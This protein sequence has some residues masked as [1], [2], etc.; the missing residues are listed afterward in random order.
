[1]KAIFVMYDSLRRDMLPCYGGNVAEMPNFKRLAERSVTFDTSYVGSL[2]CMPVRRE[3]QTGRLNFLHR[4][5]GPMEP[6]DVSMPEILKQNGIHSHLATDHYHYVQDG[7]ATYQG[8]FSSWACYR[9]QESDAWKGSVNEAPDL[10]RVMGFEKMPE[11]LKAMRTRGATQNAVNRGF[12]HGEK[13]YPQT[14]TFDDGVDFIER[15]ADADN[16]FVQIE[17]FDPHEPF[18][19][20]ES[21]TGRYFDANDPFQKD[22]PPYAEVSEDPDE[23]EKMRKKYFAL[24]T[25]CDKS[26][27]RV[28]DMMDAKDM[29]R[30]TML[31]VGTDHGFLLSEHN[32]WGKGS[33]PDY[34]EIVHTPL[35][36]YDPRSGIQNERRTQLV[37][38]I[39]IVPT[40][41]DFFGLPIPAEVQ[42]K[43]LRTVVEKRENVREYAL[44]GY[45]GG[46]IGITDGKYVYL[47]APK[48]ENPCVTE[49]TLMPTKMISF[50]PLED[51]RKATLEA[52]FSFT[53]GCPVLAYPGSFGR[54]KMPAG[55][56]LLF[57]MEHDRKQE[58]PLNDNAVKERMCRNIERLMKESDAPK[59]LYARFGLTEPREV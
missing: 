22:W 54:E 19:A 57:D 38:T 21:F 12:I 59:E 33:M 4:S 37:Q 47:L 16:W 42:G 20:P 23:V 8:R 28:L 3:L 52:P 40:V 35:F 1:M 58:H 13:D 11:L 5:W 24:L 6:Y 46:T 30:D 27:G 15:N 32:W 51:L 14:L 7:G 26:L 48:D 45:H 55:T 9:G 17:T 44:F 50:A 39:D 53:K 10:C 56:D 2:P 29:W 41:L 31:I 43:A 25:F 36:L 34:D 49:Y 18:D